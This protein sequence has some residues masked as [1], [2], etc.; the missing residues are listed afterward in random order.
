MK[1][2]IKLILAFVVLLLVTYVFYF[3]F[4]NRKTLTIYTINDSILYRAESALTPREQQTGLMY[5][6][7]LAP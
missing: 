3:Y 1:R 4:Y 2:I 5:R 6:K 7:Y